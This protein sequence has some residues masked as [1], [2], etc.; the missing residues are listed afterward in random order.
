MIP[1]AEPDEFD[2]DVM[3]VDNALDA[4]ARRRPVVADPAL[5]ALATFARTVDARAAALE[6]DGVFPH[7]AHLNGKPARRYERTPR[8]A[9]P[10]KAT[11]PSA[12]HH[13]RTRPAGKKR[14]NRVLLAIPVAAVA[15]VLAGILPFNDSPSSPLYP[16]HQLVFEP[17][18]RA[19]ESIRL[20]LASAGQALDDAASDIGPT[21]EA[22]LDQARR[23]LAEARKQLAQI[24]DSRTRSELERQLSNLEQ[25]AGQLD[26]GDDGDDGQGDG[27]DEGSRGQVEGNGDGTSATPGLTNG[28]QDGQDQFHEEDQR[29]GT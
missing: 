16:L 21:R 5:S 13:T 28:S 14:L 26:D 3:A 22:D 27:P 2:P 29:Q 25:R 7:P 23:D 9:A 11:T 20:Y 6:P 15:I 17:D 10:D 12:G 1:L 18:D 24:A 4:L 8:Q 19:A